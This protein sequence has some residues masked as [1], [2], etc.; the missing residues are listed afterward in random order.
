M[1]CHS[2]SKSK[3]FLQ[4]FFF[5]FFFQATEESLDYPDWALAVLALLII[6]AMLPVPLGLIHSFLRDRT[7]RLS[8]DAENAEYSMVRT[9]DK[10]ETPLADM[11]ELEH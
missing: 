10:F 4:S 2:F 3:R 7:T 1:Q 11:S 5:F 6:F 8:R 9:D